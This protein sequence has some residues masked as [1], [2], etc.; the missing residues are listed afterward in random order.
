LKRITASKRKGLR[1][2]RLEETKDNGNGISDSEL[3]RQCWE[4]WRHFDS[5][6]WQIPSLSVAIVGGLLAIAYYAIQETTERGLVILLAALFLLVMTL[7]LYKHRY[8]QEKRT[9]IIMKLWPKNRDFDPPFKGKSKLSAFYFQFLALM[10][11][12]IGL[13]FLFFRTIST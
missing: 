6:I 7:A 10:I 8:F 4:D 5:L 9:T 11:L 2:S 3:L 13:L 12:F 1:G